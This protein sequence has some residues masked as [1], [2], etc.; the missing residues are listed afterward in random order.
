MLS[1]LLSYPAFLL[2]VLRVTLALKGVVNPTEF[3][4]L[5]YSKQHP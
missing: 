3:L 1:N 5:Q 4:T 2:E